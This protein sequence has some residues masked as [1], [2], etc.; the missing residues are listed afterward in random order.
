MLCTC[1][2]TLCVV[3]AW[4]GT[5]C[6]V[7]TWL[8]YYV[9]H[10]KVTSVR[11]PKDASTNRVRGFGYAELPTKEDLEHALSLDGEVGREWLWLSW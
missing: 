10:S 6:V 5:L 1:L 2:G 3:C 8:V 9:S 7:C 11:L 4:L